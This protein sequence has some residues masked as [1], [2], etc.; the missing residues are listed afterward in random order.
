[1]EDAMV[2]RMFR[3]IIVTALV[4][5]TG[6]WLRPAAAD[7][8][9]VLTIDENPADCFTEAFQVGDRVSRILG[10]GSTLF[11]T[12]SQPSIK[13]NRFITNGGC[14]VD[15]A[16]AA[17]F[18][19]PAGVVSLP[20]TVVLQAGVSSSADAFAGRGFAEADV[21]ARGVVRVFN[22]NDFDIE[23][24]VTTDLFQYGAESNNALGFFAVAGL[25]AHGAN[26]ETFLHSEVGPDGC[27]T[28]R[29]H[30]VR[31]WPAVPGPDPLLDSPIDD[32]NLSQT[33]DS[34]LLPSDPSCQ[35][36]RLA[37]TIV[38]AG[39][40]R[41]LSSCIRAGVGNDARTTVTFDDTGSPI[42]RSGY[43][44][45]TTYVRCAIAYGG[46]VAPV[47]AATLEVTVHSPVDLIV[48]DANGRRTGFDLARKQPIAE[49]PGGRYTG[50]ATEPQ[51]VAVPFPAGDYD[52]QLTATGDGP[53][54]LT[55]RTLDV[56]GDELDRRET[57]GTVN[58]GDQQ[59]AQAHVNA[60]GTLGT[61][62]PADTTPPVTTASASPGPNGNGWNNTDVTVQLSAADETGG[63]GVKEIAFALSG[64]QGDSGVA[65][66]STASVTI[67]ADGATTLTYF[68]RDNAG[69]QEA[70]KSLTVRIDKT[71]PT[72]AC[73]ADPGQLWPPNHKLV[74]VTASVDE[75]DAL[76]GAAGFTLVS[77]T[78][79]EGTAADIQ[80]FVPGT[81][82]LSG[83]L[84]ADRAGTG[85][86]R[87]YTLLYRGQDLA[88]NTATCTTVVVVPHD[89][90]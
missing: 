84:R 63:S 41:D 48:T 53:F 36:Q 16:R 82:S 85:T 47:G 33:T 70:A 20:G 79:N 12:S 72:L 65:A 73:A 86:G 38:P 26:A 3:A 30:V 42:F 27:R 15:G 67:S 58:R 59:T 44:I 89:Q 6:A 37:M 46:A 29:A 40:T 54:T 68:A 18:S 71:P 11:V 4:F 51:T 14:S 1:M 83:Q 77:V 49:I 8:P 87:I 90:R 76:S 88:G 50:H 43:G 62:P 35:S 19:P 25:A 69:N 78:S 39:S 57:S 2:H 66:G 22:P 52:I 24:S 34:A 31:Q 81:A 61:A 45:G 74:P 80:G 28:H 60:A 23:L 21:D 9:L 75:T 17:T 56:N 32:P 64:A 55:I 13:D 10:L 7:Q 5:A